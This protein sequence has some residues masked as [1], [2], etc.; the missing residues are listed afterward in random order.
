MFEKKTEPVFAFE[1]PFPCGGEHWMLGEQ[2]RSSDLRGWP[3][4]PRV[5]SGVFSTGEF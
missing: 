1:A 5:D 3:F 2:T 4:L